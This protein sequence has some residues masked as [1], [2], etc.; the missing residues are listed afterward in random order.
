[1]GRHRRLGEDSCVRWLPKDLMKLIG[2]LVVADEKTT[3]AV[4]MSF[5]LSKREKPRSVAMRPGLATVF[6]S[7]VERSCKHVRNPPRALYMC[8]FLDPVFSLPRFLEL[9]ERA[10]QGVAKYLAV[11][12]VCRLELSCKAMMRRLAQVCAFQFCCPQALLRDRP[13]D[14]STEE[15]RLAWSREC[16]DRALRSAMIRKKGYAVRYPYIDQS[17]RPNSFCLQQ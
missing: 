10:L 1:M 6:G 15:M 11:G 4:V 8:A 17:K 14:W 9:P 7:K 16:R 13:K 5:A 12:D 3:D 2:G